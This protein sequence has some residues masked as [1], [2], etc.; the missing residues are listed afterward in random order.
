M[1]VA[2]GDEFFFDVIENN[3]QEMKKVQAFDLC[4]ARAHTSFPVRTRE[5][6]VFK[7]DESIQN[8]LIHIRID[9]K[10]WISKQA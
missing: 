3:F 1:D 7:L 6:F 4:R 5:S 9:H 10:K 2:C 8:G